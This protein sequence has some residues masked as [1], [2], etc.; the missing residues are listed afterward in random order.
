MSSSLGGTSLQDTVTKNSAKIRI[1]VAASDVTLS[2]IPEKWIAEMWIQAEALLNAPF[3]VMRAAGGHENA[4]SVASSHG[5]PHYVEKLACD[6][7]CFKYKSAK[8]CSHTLASAQDMGEECIE[9]F[10][11]WRRKLKREAALTP[12]VV[13]DK[14]KEGA[15]KK[16]G[17]PTRKSGSYRAPSVE[18][19]V[20]RIVATATSPKPRMSS[21]HAFEA[22]ELKMTRA[23]IFNVRSVLS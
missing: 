10:L 21:S 13:Q 11:Q 16:S 22:I 3:G 14:T 17:K 20:E 2:G 4:R 5:A 6:N 18:E 9:K 12:I 15:G 8:I 19:R 1:S 23:R 7:R